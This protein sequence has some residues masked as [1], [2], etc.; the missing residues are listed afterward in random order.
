MVVAAF[1]AVLSGTLLPAPT[2]TAAPV[3]DQQVIPPGN[4]SAA[5]NDCC[6][7]VAQTFTAGRSG[8]LTGVNVSIGASAPFQLRVGIRTTDPSGAPTSVVLAATTLD[9]PDSTLDELITFTAPPQV[10]AGVRY[11]IVV[12]YPD[13]GPQEGNGVWA[14]SSTDPYP[15]GQALFSDDGGTSWF[16]SGDYES[17][18]FFRTYVDATRTPTSPAAC[19][20]GGWRNLAT[21]RG[22]RFGSQGRCV[23]YMTAHRRAARSGG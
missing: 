18:L 7:F 19:K 1:G 4:L 21:D 3:V 11:A 20:A 8:A 2:A 14:G 9:R 13:A 23:S 6:A 17:D 15:L 22:Q 5:I 12:D 16:R 10:T